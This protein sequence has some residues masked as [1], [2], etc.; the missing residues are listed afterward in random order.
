M[1]GTIRRANQADRGQMGSHNQIDTQKN[2]QAD[3]AYNTHHFNDLAAAAIA[4]AI[5]AVAAVS[6]CCCCC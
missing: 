5:A 4:A 6:C 3:R 2:R 1:A